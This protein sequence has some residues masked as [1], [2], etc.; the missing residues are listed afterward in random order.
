[1]GKSHPDYGTCPGCT[2]ARRVRA[3]GTLRTH[4]RDVVIGGGNVK[5]TVECH[6][7]GTYY[8]ELKRGDYWP[9]MWDARSG[10]WKDLPIEVS[11]TLHDFDDQLRLT[12]IESHAFPDAKTGYALYVER[13]LGM[14]IFLT[15][16]NSYANTY[17]AELHDAEGDVL[18]TEGSVRDDGSLNGLMLRWLTQLAE[19]AKKAST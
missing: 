2:Q 9:Q 15:E 12:V 7:S 14:H 5:A 1:M 8:T 16:H 10:N 18:L 6:G 4:N 19:D 13:Q 11:T 3:D 17:R